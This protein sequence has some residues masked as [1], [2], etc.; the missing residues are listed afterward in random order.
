MRGLPF[1][2]FP[3]SDAGQARAY[4]P[5]AYRSGRGVYGPY[6]EPLQDRVALRPIVVVALLLLLAPADFSVQEITIPDSA[7]THWRF[8]NVQDLSDGGV[9]GGYTYDHAGHGSGEF[10]VP[11]VWKGGKGYRLPMGANEYAHV[12][13]VQDGMLIGDV[14]S[15]LP[16]HPA[17]WRAHPL[18]GWAEPKFE[19]LKKIEGTAT[20]D[21]KGRI[22]VSSTE[23]L[24][25]LAAPDKKVVTK[26]FDLTGVD[27]RGWIFGNR[28]ESLGVGFQRKGQSAVR[29]ADGAWGRIFPNGAK[30]STI[31]AVNRHGVGVGDLDGVAGVWW[32]NRFEPLPLGDGEVASVTDINDA[33]DVVGS[34]QLPRWMGPYPA[35]WRDGQLVNL[36][37]KVQGVALDRVEAINERRQMV[38][39]GYEKG[40][41]RLFLLTPKG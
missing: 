35:L 18:K 34:I 2:S 20:V 30:T 27:A 31:E 3:F 7:K 15:G 25:A 39:E 21:G 40:R 6:L 37:K 41:T 24:Y 38:V 9:V 8:V 33:G 32:P 10:T 12:R 29:Y 22:W 4:T 17:I 13:H 5:S 28:Y 11:F 16:W 14:R 1:R 36:P 26:Q 23:G 19:V